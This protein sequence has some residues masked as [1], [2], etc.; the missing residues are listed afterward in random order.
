VELLFRLSF[1]LLLFQKSSPDVFLLPGAGVDVGG[2]SAVYCSGLVYLALLAGGP[3]L[4][5]ARSPP[6]QAL[7]TIGW[8]GWP[9]VAGPLLENGLQFFVSSSASDGRSATVLF[10]GA[11]A[12]SV[13]LALLLSQARVRNTFLVDI[14][15]SVA[16]LPP[17]PPID[18]LA[19]HLS[20]PLILDPHTGVRVSLE[21]LV[22]LSPFLVPLLLLTLAKGLDRGA[23]AL[24]QGAAVV[25]W[26]GGL[27]APGPRAKATINGGRQ[28]QWL[29]RGYGV[30]SRLV[31]RGALLILFLGGAVA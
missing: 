26:D 12:G 10:V 27:G 31:H 22:Q 8:R 16:P 3:S 29:F 7:K 4:K 9:A 28:G 17:A 24:A 30:R 19:R 14:R 11:L 23:T 15:L 25:I 13:F 18:N 2:V 5:T 6:T 21:T 1:E 20:T